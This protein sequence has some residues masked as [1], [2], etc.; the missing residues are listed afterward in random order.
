MGRV[1]HGRQTVQMAIALPPDIYDD[2]VK[3]VDIKSNEYGEKYTISKIG[4]K[5]MT[6]WVE[7]QRKKYGDLL[8]ED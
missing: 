4:C 7:K 8:R 2:I 1:P 6:R 5:V 3:L